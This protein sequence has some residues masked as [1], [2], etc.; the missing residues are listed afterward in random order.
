M[1]F[2]ILL[3]VCFALLS[4]YE[5]VH[6]EDGADDASLASIDLATATGPEAVHGTWRYSDV[7]LV[8]TRDRARTQTANRQAPSSTRGIT[9][10]GQARATSTTRSGRRSSRRP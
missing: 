5:R 4:P 10:R 8:R 3:Y 9:C 7:E 1:R 2:T 6:A